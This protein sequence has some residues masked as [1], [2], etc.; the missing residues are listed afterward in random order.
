MK[1]IWRWRCRSE[2]PMLDEE[3][4]ASI[5][6]LYGE[7]MSATQEFRRLRNLPLQGMTIDERFGPVRL[8]YEELTGLVGCHAN[9]VIHHRLSLYGS[10]CKACGKPLRTP[11][12]KLCAACM[13]AVV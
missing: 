11:K 12:A 5:S 3:E 8:R 13:T 7:C 9:V 2:V 4:F 1:V 6:Q 10:P